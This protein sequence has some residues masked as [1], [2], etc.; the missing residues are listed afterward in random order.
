MRII[1]PDIGAFD[2]MPQTKHPSHAP[3]LLSSV[4]V[5]RLPARQAQAHKGDFGH[6][7]VVGGD[8]G[9]GGAA[10]LSAEAA[11][12]CGAG[13]VS[14]ATR[15]EH[16]AAGLTR[17]PE[18]MCLGV[19]S[20]NQLMAVLERASVLVVGPGLGQAAWG[21]SLLSAVANAERPQVW[22]A[23]AL[24]LLA[25]TPLALPSGSI[26][27]PHP[28]KRRGCWGFLPRRCRSTARAPR[29]S[30]RGVTTVSACS[31]ALARWSPTRPGSCCCASAATRPWPVPAWAMC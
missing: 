25:R 7:L 9:T 18:A 3:Q 29:A 16:V 24:N 13:L 21:R 6:V 20:A 17:M 30:W 8:L 27:T 12:R 23:D 4:S 31:R 2:R 26:L 22:D 15:P 1:L 14:V 19:E 11:P 5:A 10:L 28:G